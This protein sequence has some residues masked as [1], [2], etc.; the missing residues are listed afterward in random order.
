VRWADELVHEVLVKEF[1]ESELFYLRKRVDW[2]EG[3]HGTRI[4]LN[5]VVI[6]AVW[7]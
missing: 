6:G 3:R 4:Q 7:W 2:A 1:L 5:F